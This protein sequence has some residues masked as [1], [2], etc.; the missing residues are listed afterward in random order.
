[1]HG[2]HEGYLGQWADQRNVPLAAACRSCQ[3]T[4]EGAKIL[5]IVTVLVE[6]IKPNECRPGIAGDGF[7]LLLRRSA[8]KVRCEAGTVPVKM[9]WVAIGGS[10]IHA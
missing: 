10:Q 7:V 4:A 3:R 8:S 9:G 2:V 5:A 6:L 1:M